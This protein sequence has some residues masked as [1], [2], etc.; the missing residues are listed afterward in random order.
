MNNEQTYL[1]TLD[2]LYGF[3]DYSL[4]RGGF[5]DMVGKFELDR[6]RDFAEF[7]GNPHN[8]YPILHV[9]G[10][11]GKGTVC[12]LCANALCEAGYRVGLYTSPHLLD[13]AE[14]I[15]VDGRPIAH[16]E[17]IAL[18]DEIRPYLDAGTKLT[19]FEITTGLALRYFAQ[20]GCT[21]V[22]LEVGLGGRLDATN[23]VMPA[24]S[25]IT[26]LSM[27]HMAVL[28]NTL[29]E[30]A[31]EKA[32]I[33]KPGVPVVVAPQK[34]EARQVIE[35]IAA[36]RDAELVQVGEALKF[37]PGAH[38]LDGQ[39]LMVWH[40]D[41]NPVVLNIPL[42][43]AHMAENAA[44]AYAALLT[45]EQS[46]L[47]LD[48]ADIQRG[49]AGVRWPGRFEIL[50]RQPPVVIDAA[51]NR[52]SAARLRQALD[53]YFPTRRVVLVFGASDDKDINGMMDEL[54]GRVDEVI[55]TRSFHP[56]AADPQHLRAIIDPYGKTV[57]VIEKIE[58]ALA[59]GL[60]RLGP[61]DM[62]LVA[63]SIFIAAGARETWYKLKSYD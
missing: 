18:V 23:I 10:T 4:T 25:V 41:G 11:K 16:D 58:D 8:A 37:Q 54:L 43:G 13:Y 3:V 19:T 2:Y 61:N 5:A 55:L 32:G 59:Q 21:A 45:V 15:Q 29:A 36:E 17:L 28:G 49:F 1:K 12:A 39:R 50:Q 62:L 60:E 44:V 35:R 9:A 33:I 30:I 7:L 26:S 27:D 42:L 6:M 47:H 46:W 38:T 20:R 57:T 56:R 22:V 31:A 14:R 40:T 53:D 24:V 52:S 63:G 34:P 48:T 51:H